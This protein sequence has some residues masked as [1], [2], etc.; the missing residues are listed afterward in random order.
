MNPQN[1]PFVRPLD[2]T[3]I[4]PPH[5]V[6]AA[7]TP[8][9]WRRLRALPVLT[10][11]CDFSRCCGWPH[12]VIAIVDPSVVRRDL[13]QGCL[14]PDPFFWRRYE[15]RLITSGDLDRLHARYLLS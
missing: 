14:Y 5:D 12:T 3:F 2:I 10:Y 7:T 6:I 9:E 15:F 11:T 1:T 4:D 8:A 13:L